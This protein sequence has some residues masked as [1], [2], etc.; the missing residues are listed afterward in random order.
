MSLIYLCLASLA[1]SEPALLPA[2][3]ALPARVLA[4]AP[5]AVL[6]SRLPDPVDVECRENCGVEENW[7]DFE[8]WVDA[9]KKARVTAEVQSTR[10]PGSRREATSQGPRADGRFFKDLSGSATFRDLEGASERLGDNLG[11]LGFTH[12]SIAQADFFR[13]MARGS[14][15]AKYVLAHAA[16]TG[17]TLAVVAPLVQLLWEWEAE[18]GRTPKGQVRAILLV[19]TAE[20]GQE[21]LE[22]AREVAKRSIRASLATGEGQ[23]WATQRERLRG[24]LDLLVCTLGRL[25]AHLEPRERRDG[26]VIPP[27][28]TLEGTRALVLEEADSLYAYA[29]NA[30][31]PRQRMSDPRLDFRWV[32]DGL[33][34]ACTVAL[35]TASVS[36]N[37]EEQVA[38]DLGS[39]VRY[40]RSRGLHTTRPGVHTTLVALD[41]GVPLGGRP[42][43]FAAK[44]EALLEELRVRG[45]LRTLVLCS[46]DVS[47]DR[48][49]RWL[50]ASLDPSKVELEVFHSQERP[51]NRQQALVDFRRPPPAASSPLARPDRRILVATARAVRGLRLSDAEEQVP[52][53]H[54]VLFDFPPNGKEYIARVGFATRGDAAVPARVTAFAVPQQLN[55]ANALLDKDEE[56]AP[57]LVGVHADEDKN[58]RGTRDKSQ[59]V[60]RDKSQKVR[61][62]DDTRDKGQKVMV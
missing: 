45:T 2:L 55:F 27:S 38:A 51:E 40:V 9:E 28:F 42:S 47:A 56:G 36:A 14:P 17:K 34:A 4:R 49:A 46:T 44:V 7:E 13:L 60:T 19:P 32:L 15:G 5:T 48:L 18:H 33:P 53:G 52:L 11:R 58:A 62:P 3:R 8:A 12:P 31:Y 22:L 23:K 61:K 50:D 21:I 1:S 54:V 29:D 20:L 35:V 24:G 57:I 16:G 25:V 26:T 43:F 6:Q 39:K 41:E 37:F 30:L 10:A 59:K